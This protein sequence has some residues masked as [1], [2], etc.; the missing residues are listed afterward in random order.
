MMKLRTTASG[1]SVAKRIKEWAQCLSLP[2]KMMESSYGFRGLR[3][4]PTF[5]DAATGFPA[6]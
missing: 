1:P 3:K 6:K 5:G 4:Q 2:K